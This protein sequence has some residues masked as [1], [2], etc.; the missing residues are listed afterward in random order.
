M[1]L[2]QVEGSSTRQA[3]H[4]HH[5]LGA[6]SLLMLAEG[7]PQ[8]MTCARIDTVCVCVPALF[9]FNYPQL[10]GALKASTNRAANR[11]RLGGIIGFL[12]V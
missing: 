10:E 7:D 5:R 3:H 9:G 6:G 8:T 2:Y 4:H 11:S 12:N 1:G